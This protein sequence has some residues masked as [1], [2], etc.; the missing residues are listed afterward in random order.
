MKVKRAYKYRFYP[1]SEQRQNLAQTFG[2]VR[3][4]YNY[5]LNLRTEAF[6]KHGE[7]VNYHDTSFLLANMKKNSSA[8]WLND[9][10]SVPLQQGLRHLHTAFLNFWSK[11]SGYPKFKRKYDKQSATYAANAFKWD[12]NN[13]KLAKQ[14]EPLNIRWSRQF[15]GKPSTVT[16]SKD[17]VGRYF[18]SILVEE[19]IQ[20]LPPVKNQVGVDLGIKDVIVTS[21]GFK[22]GSPAYTRKYEKKLAKAQ[23]NLAKKKKCSKNREKA[24]LKVARIH[25]KIAD[26]RRDFT[27]KLT[28]KLVRENNIICIETLAVKNMVKNR[29][30]AKSIS[31][32]GWGELTRQLEYKS[33][34]YGRKL[35]AI[36]RWFPS[37]KRCFDCGHINDNLQLSDRNWACAECGVEHDRDINASR[38][39]LAAGLAVVSA[40]GEDVRLESCI[41]SSKPR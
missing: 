38:N 29:C 35:I 11:R 20:P 7:K 15:T 13:L 12:G 6:Y 23:R 24:R 18:V 30:L 16:V 40:F 25:A 27:H 5:M 1:D 10:S 36:D 21:D 26:S 8:P 39:I 19:D 9:V 32:S 4:T 3:F 28:T 33:D 14:K 41:G 37:S 22:S 17:R 34:W 31:D 2:C